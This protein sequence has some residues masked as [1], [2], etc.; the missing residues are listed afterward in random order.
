[1]HQ[2][3]QQDKIN[4]SRELPISG[5][6]TSYRIERISA[7][8]QAA[9][10][11][12]LPR[13]RK[14]ALNPDNFLDVFSQ[15]AI[16]QDKVAVERKK[17]RM[18]AVDS[19]PHRRAQL[20]EA[21]LAEQIELSDW[22]GG[23]AETITPAEY[24]DLFNGIDLAIEFEDDTPEN[25]TQ[26][27]YLSLGIDVISG[28]GSVKNKIYRIRENIRNGSFGQ[29]KY[30]KSE[31]NNDQKPP[32]THIPAFII[33]ADPRT[34]N[35]LATLWLIGNRSITPS[36]NRSRTELEESR[37]EAKKAKEKLGK[38]PARLLIILELLAQVD[39]YYTY[40]QTA[41]IDKAM[42]KKY[43]EIKARL[44]GILK[45]IKSKSPQ[46]IHEQERIIR[47]DDVFVAISKT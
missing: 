26:Y 11:S 3:P 22:L 36:A 4:M 8:E 7:N 45:E 16:D 28:P 24:D 40:A 9:F 18:D 21:I 37:E 42:L 23:N 15:Q 32:L 19:P 31:R 2:D 38:H 25:T 29:M 1:M 14:L 20:L 13:H 10:D 30:F 12:L 5:S 33:G 39:A 44:E 6:E 46:L 47:N 17:A 41:G 34:I 27:K 35:D 43:D